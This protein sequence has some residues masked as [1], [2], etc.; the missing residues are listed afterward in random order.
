MP[1]V[2]KSERSKIGVVCTWEVELKFS[3]YD[4]LTRLWL[5][6]PGYVF[7]AS[8]MLRGVTVETRKLGSWPS[9]I[10]GHLQVKIWI[11]VTTERSKGFKIGE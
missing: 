10:A 3:K 11:Y 7:E 5:V 1:S 9:L 4:V 8:G 6:A 2:T